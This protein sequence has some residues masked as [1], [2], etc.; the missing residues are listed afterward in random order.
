MTIYRA[1]RRIRSKKQG[2]IEEGQ[3]TRLDWLSP[4]EIQSLI[5]RGVIRREESPKLEELAGWKTRG[6]RL[7]TL[8]INTAEDFL[9]AD[10]DWLADELH[11]KPETVEKW[12]KELSIWFEAPPAKRG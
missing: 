4:G 2:I 8:D 5:Q 11:V 1:N 9:D 10:P 7:K 12:G 3:R 6:R